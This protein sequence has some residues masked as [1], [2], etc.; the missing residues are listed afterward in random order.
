MRCEGGIDRGYWG[1]LGGRFALLWI[2]NLHSALDK[3]GSGTLGEVVVRIDWLI[4]WANPYTGVTFYVLYHIGLH[5][6]GVCMVRVGC[7]WA[8]TGG[9]G[10]S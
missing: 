9:S 6:G 8:C 5:L 2:C 4:G 10:H 1:I 7:V 3:T